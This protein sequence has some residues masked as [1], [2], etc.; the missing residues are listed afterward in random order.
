MALKTLVKVIPV[1]ALLAAS[2]GTVLA[3]DN[4]SGRSDWWQ[5]WGMGQM[6][7]NGPFGRGLMMEQG[8]MM[9]FGWDGMTDRI[10]GRLAFIKAELGIRDDQSAQWDKFADAARA[11]AENHNGLMK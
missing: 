1:L 11:N 10:D 8:P 4:D 7:M 2:G 6:M 5:R 3:E 9:A